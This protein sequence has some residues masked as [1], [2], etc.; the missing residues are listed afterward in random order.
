MQ[1]R[2]G[3]EDV[4]RAVRRWTHCQP[5]VSWLFYTCNQVLNQFTIVVLGFFFVEGVWKHVSMWYNNVCQCETFH[6]V[7][8][9]R[10]TTPVLTARLVWYGLLIF[11]IVWEW[12]RPHPRAGLLFPPF[13]VPHHRFM[14]YINVCPTWTYFKIS[15]CFLPLLL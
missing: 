12:P 6:Q 13:T 8:A 5:G 7:P 11:T 9:R 3:T 10:Q 1:R 2:L 14:S 4:W 15:F